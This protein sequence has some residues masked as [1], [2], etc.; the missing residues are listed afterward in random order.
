MARTTI[1]LDEDLLRRLKGEV[2]RTGKPFKQVVNTVLR[3]GLNRNHTASKVPPFEVRGARD[4][5]SYPG[6]D[7][8][9]IGTLLE[10][11][12]GLRHK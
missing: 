10:Y 9:N 4:L 12:E 5:G 11:N 8:D 7:Y 3:R 2:R 6:L 1:T